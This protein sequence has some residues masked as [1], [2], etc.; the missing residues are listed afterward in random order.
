MHAIQAAAAARS[1]IEDAEAAA[2]YR[3]SHGLVGKAETRGE[4]L[5]IGVNTD[6]PVD[7]E[8]GDLHFARVDVE[9]RLAVGD[10]DRRRDVFVAQ[11]QIQGEPAVHSQIVGS[12]EAQFQ[13]A[14][15]RPDQLVIL[16][17]R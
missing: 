15:S 12:V 5:M 1:V 8:S 14:V 3:V 4:Q 11:T 7:V 10:L 13:H 17:E 16:A 2:H 6:I 9:V